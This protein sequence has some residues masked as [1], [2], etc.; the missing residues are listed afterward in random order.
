MCL[1]SARETMEKKVEF[2]LISVDG[3]F[4]LENGAVM[5]SRKQIRTLERPELG[6]DASIK[7]EVS[8]KAQQA[9]QALIAEKLQTEDVIIGKKAG[10]CCG[11]PYALFK[12]NGE[13]TMVNVS[14]SHSE[15][16]FAI[17]FSA[18]R[19]V[20]IDLQSEIKAEGSSL[21]AFFSPEESR[22]LTMLAVEGGLSKSFAAT[23]IWTIKEAFLKA[24]GVGFRSGF[25][26][27][28]VVNIDWKQR[29]MA[30]YFSDQVSRFFDCDQKL[31][32]Y[33]APG[34]F[35]MLTI[36]VINPSPSF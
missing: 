5:G 19:L 7:R 14:I 29:E 34:T 1:P 8:R 13:E 21:Q 20:G 18:S 30:L 17:C 2:H 6:T 22:V 9:L 25:H 27:L 23:L 24:V 31:T 28:S 3:N 35:Q 4:S 15:N 12:S 11:Q 26:G 10:V 36:A 16:V 33:I 32:L